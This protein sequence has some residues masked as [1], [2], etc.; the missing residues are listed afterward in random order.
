VYAIVEAVRD[1]GEPMI[2]GCGAPNVIA[3]LWQAGKFERFPLRA[4]LVSRSTP[5]G[6]LLSL[7]PVS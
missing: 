3:I 4:T 1:N 5:N 6:D 7:K 2:Y